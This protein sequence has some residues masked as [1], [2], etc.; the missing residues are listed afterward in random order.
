MKLYTGC[1]I[2]QYP[3]F[4]DHLQKEEEWYERNKDLR[5]C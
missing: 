3:A 5:V 2:L 1:W 4:T